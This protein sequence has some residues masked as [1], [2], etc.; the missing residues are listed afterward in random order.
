MAQLSDDCFAFG[1][2]LLPIEAARSLIFGQVTVVAGRNG[3]RGR[4]GPGLQLRRAAHHGGRADL[5]S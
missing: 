5:L 2:A 1:G 3:D 4:Y